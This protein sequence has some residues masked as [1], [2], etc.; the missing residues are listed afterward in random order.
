MIQARCFRDCV[1]EPVID[2][3]KVRFLYRQG[4]L[5]DIDPEASWAIWFEDPDTGKRIKEP[6]VSKAQNKNAFPHKGKRRKLREAV[7]EA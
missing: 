1:G 4:T 6:P 5:Y 7:A 2:G 3:K